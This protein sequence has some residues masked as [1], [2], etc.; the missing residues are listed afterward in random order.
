ML[1]GGHKPGT[2]V[3]RDARLRPLLERGDQS[4]LRELFGQTHITH[5]PRETS[6]DPG[7]LDPPDRVDRAMRMGSR[8]GYPSHHLQSAGASRTGRHCLFASVRTGER[9]YAWGAKSSG[10][11]TWRTSVSPSQPGQCFLCSSMKRNAPSIAS[12]FDFNSKTAY[13]QTTSMASV[14]G[15]SIAVTCPLERRTRVL[16]AVEASP[17]LEII[18]PALT[19]S[20]PSLS[21][22]SINAWGGG[23]DLSADLTIIMNRIVISPFD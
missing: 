16:T 17:P 3:V 5:D 13:P 11:N 22:A 19:A 14:K 21:M 20:W 4:V 23:P 6:N 18:V 10:P 15:P 8:H 2:R 1:R 9:C 12:F 7:G